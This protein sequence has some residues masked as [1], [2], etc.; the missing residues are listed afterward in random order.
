MDTRTLNKA[1]GAATQSAPLIQITPE[2]LARRLDHIKRNMP[3]TYELIVKKAE[4][5]GG[6]VF[7]AVRQGC[8][9]EPNRFWAME[10]GH[11]AGTAFNMRSVEQEVA[12]SMV[13]FGDDWAIVFDPELDGGE[14]PASAGDGGGGN[15]AH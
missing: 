14:R 10:A 6:A 9:G 5:E 11:F 2:E 3:K 15:G 1:E 13:N 7:R 8:M 12:W 4:M